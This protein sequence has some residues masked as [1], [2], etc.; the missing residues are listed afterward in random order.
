MK[1]KCSIGPAMPLM[2]PDRPSITAY[3]ATRFAACIGLL[4]VQAL[5]L[6][7]RAEDTIRLIA[8][9]AHRAVV[10]I[11]NERY[12][13]TS[14]E[15]DQNGVSLVSSST[16]EVVIRVDGKLV[17]LDMFSSPAPVL[18]EPETSTERTGDS[19]VLWMSGDG[20][21][22]AD[23]TI[24][25]KLTRF[26]VDTGATSVALSGNEA[27]RLGINWKKGKRGYS[28]T[29][30]GIVPRR[31]FVADEITVQGIT[32]RRVKVSVIPGSFPEIPLLG[33]TF[34]N[35]L[36]M[37]RTGVRMDLSLP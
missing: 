10:E 9:G 22:Y 34:L 5:H 1:Q 31:S 29:V 14:L 15:P 20:F 19:A 18:Q 24:N 37:T 12:V 17:R 23:G 27:N 11:N 8:A 13:L 36:N 26:V 16:G 32:L 7:A 25:G 4:L 6:T 3:T 28:S 35:K 21:F 33:G 2:N 30:G